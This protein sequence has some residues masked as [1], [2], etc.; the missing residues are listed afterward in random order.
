[1][2]PLPGKLQPGSWVCSDWRLL[3]ACL[4]NLTSPCDFYTRARLNMRQFCLSH[5]DRRILS[6]FQD[7]NSYMTVSYRHLHSSHESNC[8]VCINDIK[9]QDHMKGEYQ[10]WAVWQSWAGRSRAH[11][12]LAPECTVWRSA[13]LEP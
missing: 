2:R 3:I 6:R 10:W 4:N 1:M 13:D 12:L 7:A 9:T 5:L 11:G 8:G